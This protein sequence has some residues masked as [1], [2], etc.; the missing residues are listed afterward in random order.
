MGHFGVD[1]G[2]A[3]SFSKLLKITV[4]FVVAEENSIFILKDLPTY[5]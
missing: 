3:K 5:V 2:F 4:N 1:F